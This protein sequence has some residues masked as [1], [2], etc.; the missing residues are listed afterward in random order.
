[1]ILEN[2]K[3]ARRIKAIFVFIPLVF[4]I[5]VVA[6]L[7]LNINWGFWLIL[8][9]AI[10]MILLFIIVSIM[11]YN[12]FFCEIDKD[13]MIFKFHGL[14]PMNKEYKTIK[15]HPNHFKTFQINHRFFGLVEQLVLFVVVKNNQVAKYPPISISALST[16]EKENLKKELSLFEKKNK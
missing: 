7:L 11:Q 10:L 15:I 2:I 14:G 1:M 5:S 6:L 9:I 12:Y 16:E 8:A 13:K 3:N 4:V